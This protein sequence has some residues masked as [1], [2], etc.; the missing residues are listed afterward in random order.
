MNRTDMFPRFLL[1]NLT[2]AL[3]DT[4]AVL[5][6]GPRQSG[7]TTLV[8]MLGDTYAYVTFDDETTLTAA[9][10]DP[11]GF[12]DRLPAYCILDEVQLVPELFRSIKRVIDKD[13]YAGRFVLTGSANLMLIPQLADSLAGRLE[14]LRLYPLSQSEINARGT[15]PIPGMFK[16]V[17]PATGSGIGYEELLNRVLRGGF[18]EPVKR[19]HPSRRSA[20]YRNYVTTIIDRDLKSIASIHDSGSMP[21]LLRVLAN[22][23]AQLINISGMAPAFQITRPTLKHYTDLLSRVFMVDFL[24]PFYRNRMKRLVKTPKVHL[25]DTGLACAIMNVSADHLRKDHALFG[26][27]VETFVYNELRRLASELSGVVDF[28]HFRDRDGYEVD[29]VLEDSQGQIVGIEVKASSTIKAEDFSGLKKLQRSMNYQFALGIILSIGE[30]AI[31]AGE[32]I[33]ALPISSLW[34]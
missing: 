9:E 8:Q 23:T 17:I 27:I 5:V 21:R 34:T 30:R 7:K 12:V 32:G 22:Q 13:R 28:Y 33:Y 31:K 6:Q 25:T 1:E 24:P 3:S 26:H 14:I 20:W 18:P 15:N 19:E 16:G 10:L 2:V 11:I 29:I 4:P